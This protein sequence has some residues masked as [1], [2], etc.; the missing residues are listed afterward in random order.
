ME[1]KY[2]LKLDRYHCHDASTEKEF[3]NL[4][5]E[6]LWIKDDKR[7]DYLVKVSFFNFNPLFF[8]LFFFTRLPLSN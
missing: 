6:Q 3:A 5:G 1:K 8:F 7:Y 2:R 4:Y